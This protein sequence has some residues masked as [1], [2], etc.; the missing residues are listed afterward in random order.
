MLT[1]AGFD[2]STP[3]FKWFS[4]CIIRCIVPSVYFLSDLRALIR[5]Y[6]LFKKREINKRVWVYIRNLEGGWDYQQKYNNS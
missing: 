4:F 3:P 5:M 2:V 6:R 1:E